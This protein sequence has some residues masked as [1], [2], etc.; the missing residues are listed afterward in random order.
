MKTNKEFNNCTNL[1]FYRSINNN[2]IMLFRMTTFKLSMK[3]HRNN[4][5]HMN[6]KTKLLIHP[7]NLLMN[8]M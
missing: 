7:S 6:N 8:I 1:K 5:K 3:Y 4:I 2:M